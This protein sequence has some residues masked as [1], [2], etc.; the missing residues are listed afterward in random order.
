VA[1]CVAGFGENGTGAVA[2]TLATSRRGMSC[3]R[4]ILP[5][6]GCVFPDKSMLDHFV[7]ARAYVQQGALAA[8]Q[9][10]IAGDGSEG[11]LKGVLLCSLAGLSTA[12]V[13]MFLDAATILRGWPLEGAMA[14]WTAW[15]GPAAAT[16]FK[17][18]TRRCLLGVARQLDWRG[19]P[20]EV[21]LVHDVLV[22]L[23]RG[24]VLYD[25]PGLEGHW[26]SRVWKEG[27]KVVGRQQVGLQSR[28]TTFSAS[29]LR[30]CAWTTHKASS[31]QSVTRRV[32]AD[33]FVRLID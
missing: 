13:N 12:E 5:T 21:L 9:Q 25:T 18:L 19:E 17:E 30:A 31:D 15:H 33:R 2:P 22:V 6:C 1:S 20:E 10:G 7:T 24:V 32:L 23:G 27:G 3:L 16:F 8:L 28:L 11:R 4:S 26:G 14:L 29:E